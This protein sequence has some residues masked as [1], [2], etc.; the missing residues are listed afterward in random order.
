MLFKNVF[1]SFKNRNRKKKCILKNNTKHN[2]SI[3]YM[4]REEF[5]I[6]MINL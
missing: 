1:F 3:L 5:A 2:Q 6:E 4:E